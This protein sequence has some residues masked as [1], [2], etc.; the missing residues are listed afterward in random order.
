LRVVYYNQG[1]R[2][3]YRLTPLPVTFD[4]K[5]GDLFVMKQADNANSFDAIV[6]GTSDRGFKSLNLALGDSRG[7][8]I[9]DPRPF[10]ELLGEAESESFEDET[11]QEDRE[12]LDLKK[13]IESSSPKHLMSVTFDDCDFTNEE[14]ALCLE[15]VS[16]IYRGFGGIG[17]KIVENHS[18]FPATIPVE[19]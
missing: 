18:H 2:D 10:S 4:A 3:E 6:V 17:L 11:S 16:E 13:R 12:L 7:A 8:I 9:E 15:F 19:V 5:P 14:K 1:T